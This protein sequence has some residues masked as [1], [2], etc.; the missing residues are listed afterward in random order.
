MEKATETWVTAPDRLVSSTRR[1]ACVVH[2]YPTGP[3]MGARYALTDTPMVL[4]RG[5]DCDIRI[6]DHSVSRRHARIQPGADGYLRRRSPEHQRHLRQR[7]ARLHLQTQ[8]RRL[9][10]RR[11]LHLPL[12]GR[13]QR[14]SRVSRRNLSPH[15]HRRPDRHS[16]QT[17]SP[18]VPRPRA[19]ALGPLRPAAGAGPVRPRPIQE[20]Q[21]GA[22]PPRRRFHAPRGRR[23]RQGPTSARKSCSPATAARSSPSCCRRRRWK[24]ASSSPSASAARWNSA[25]SSTKASRSR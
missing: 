17:L 4:G 9:P 20:H 18:G 14:R 21:R 3:G 23:L 6:N 22:R 19:V 13:R 16:Q 25:V 15:H 24:A 2:I 10:P 1:D 8:R 5:N 12:P 7:R 11:Q